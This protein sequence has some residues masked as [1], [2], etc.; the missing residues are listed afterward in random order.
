MPSEEG[1]YA[2]GMLFLPILADDD[3]L[4]ATGDAA[5]LEAML[6]VE[7]ALARAE[8]LHG[9]I[10]E[11]AARAV[12]AACDASLYDASQ[13]GLAARGGGNPVIPLVAAI[14]QHVPRKHRSAVHLGV[15]SQDV[16]DTALVLVARSACRLIDRSLEVLVR[17]TRSLATDH[18]LTPMIGRTLMQKALPT[19]FGLKAAQWHLEAAGAR[20]ELAR[21]Q[22]MLPLQLGGASGGLDV[23]GDRASAVSETMAKELGV[24]SQ[25]VPWHTNRLPVARLGCALAM[26]AG[27]AGKLAKDVVL[28]SSGEVGEVAEPAAWGRGISS[29]MPHKTN[30]VLSTSTLAAAGTAPALASV[31]LS[32]MVAEHERPAGAWH[33]EWQSLTTL[34]RLAGG[35]AAHMGEVMAGLRVFPERM[36]SNMEGP[37]SEASRREAL[38]ASAHLVERVLEAALEVDGHA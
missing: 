1:R 33:A 7:A 32:S 25:G 18:R 10:G 29:S 9:V 22:A 5:W 30:P 35:A 14:R 11:E 15:A 31:M 3:M 24:F 13:I 17:A 4:A 6:A 19:T 27:M 8:A 2:Q 34:L 20:A 38:E 28:L 37:G 36:R 26:V 21:A 16:L 12:G 23:L